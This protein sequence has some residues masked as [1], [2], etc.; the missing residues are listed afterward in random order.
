MPQI[1]VLGAGIAGISVGYHA[2][3]I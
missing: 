2:N 3:K 1:V